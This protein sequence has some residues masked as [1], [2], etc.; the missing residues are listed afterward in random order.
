MSGHSKWSKIKHKKGAADKA[1]SNLF[2]KL[3]RAVTV[4]AQQ[5][6]GDPE[7]NFAL[8][9]AIQKAKAGNMPKDNIDRAIKKGTGD[10]KDAAVFEEIVYEGFGP[11]GVGILVETLTDNKNRTASEVKYAFS[12]NGGSLGGPG[13]VQWQFE[14]LGVVRIATSQLSEKNLDK[15][16]M[17]LQLI[18]AGADDIVEGDDGFEV[19]CQVPAFKKVLDAVQ[20]LG[21]E[22][23]DSGLEWVAKEQVDASD[24]DMKKV[25][26]IYNAL[27]ELDDVRDVYMNV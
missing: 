4:A 23:D 26:N 24:E 12:K 14:H 15:D 21:V 17:S 22:P 13:S 16:G 1:R 9:L 11:A 20:E 19:R 2:T 18:D 5:G 8:R 27:D 25:E 3:G 7:M 10:G 6:G